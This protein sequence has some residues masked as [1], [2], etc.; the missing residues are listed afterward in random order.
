LLND[1]QAPPPPR[2]VTGMEQ[3]H[4]AQDEVMSAWPKYGDLRDSLRQE[5]DQK[6]N[7]KSR[8][9]EELVEIGVLLREKYWDAGGDLSPTSYRYGYMARV[10][11]ELAHAREPNDLAIGDELA[12]TIMSIQTMGRE[13]FWPVLRDLRAAQ[14]RQTCAEVESGRQPV[15]EDF[16]RGCDMTYLFSDRRGPEEGVPV[17]DWLI[18]HAQAGGWV[19]YLDLLEQMRSQLAKKS[20]LGYNIHAPGEFPEEFRYG[21]RLPSFRGPAKRAAVPSRPL[22]PQPVQPQNP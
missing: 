15:W 1:N 5:L 11:L 7:L 8:S 20:G 22:Q 2:A 19:A 9:A 3:I 4:A 18:S 12:E 17:V 16:A 13:D 21:N 6:L 10:L 14:F